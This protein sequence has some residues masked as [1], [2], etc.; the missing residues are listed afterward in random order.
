MNNSE[1]AAKML[2]WEQTQVKADALALEIREAVLALGKTQTV[3]NV[4][5]TY[6]AGRKSYD[7]EDAALHHIPVDV[8]QKYMKPTFDYR[9]A[10]KD[11][12]VTDIPFTES[13]PSV[14]IKLV[15]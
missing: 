10:C 8:I 11:F 15:G 2:E 12:G 6:S 1:L 4:R 7:Y 14:T 3:G 5:A 9:N 13:A